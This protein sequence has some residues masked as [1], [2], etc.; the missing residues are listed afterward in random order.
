MSG[1]GSVR[2]SSPSGGAHARALPRSPR[3][4]ALSPA[5]FARCYTAYA[6]KRPIPLRAPS[7]PPAGGGALSLGGAL[8]LG[9]ANLSLGEAN[10]S[11]QPRR[12]NNP[13]AKRRFFLLCVFCLCVWLCV[14]F[15][16]FF[17]FSSVCSFWFLCSGLFFLVCSVRLFVLSG[18]GTGLS[19][20]AP[21]P[22]RTRSGGPPSGWSGRGGAS[23]V[24]ARA[25]AE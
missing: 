24:E 25:A 10:L 12:K 14:H 5:S 13:G 11:C 16:V 22:P 9:E 23:G 7:P 3:S 15:C 8:T 18:S 17:M 4:P 20:C 19:R 1:R 2:G 21:R 6:V